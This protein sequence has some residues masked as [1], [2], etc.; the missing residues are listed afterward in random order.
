[1]HRRRKLHR[2]LA[3]PATFVSF[4]VVRDFLQFGLPCRLHFAQQLLLDTL[5]MP[6]E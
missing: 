6:L 4:S 1:M 5:S 2:S 3:E